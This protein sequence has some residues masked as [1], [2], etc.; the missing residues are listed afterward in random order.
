MSLDT[1]PLDE[2]IFESMLQGRMEVELLSLGKRHCVD[3]A[4][5]NDV[6]SDVASPT[7]APRVNVV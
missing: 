2:M 3:A 4:R 5:M 6:R 7:D 1:M